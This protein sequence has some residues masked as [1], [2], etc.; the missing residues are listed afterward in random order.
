MEEKSMKRLMVMGMLVVLMIALPGCGIGELFNPTPDA[1]LT[2]EQ[3]AEREQ[4][5]QA[6]M[7]LIKALVDRVAGPIGEGEAAQW[8]IDKRD[9]IQKVLADADL[10]WLAVEAFGSPTEAMREKWLEYRATI[11]GVIDT[12]DGFLEP[13]PVLEPL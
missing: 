10:F 13:E 9:E 3:R 11:Q 6:K 12:I 2:P 5:Q 8:Y 1:D 7:D 4:Q